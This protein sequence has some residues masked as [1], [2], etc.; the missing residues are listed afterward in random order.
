[1]GP[2]PQ[3]PVLASSGNMVSTDMSCH[4]TDDTL[5]AVRVAASPNTKIV[6]SFLA[7]AKS[8]AVS[9]AQLLQREVLEPLQGTLAAAAKGQLPPQKWRN[10]VA[11]ILEGV[12]AD[13][14]GAFWTVS[15]LIDSL[16][17][18]LSAEAH[19]HRVR[20]ALVRVQSSNTA[21]QAPSLV[22]LLRGATMAGDVELQHRI[23]AAL[24]TLAPPPLGVSGLVQSSFLSAHGL[25]ANS[26]SSSLAATDRLLVG[27]EVSESTESVLFSEAARLARQGDQRGSKHGCLLVNYSGGI[28]GQDGLKAARVDGGTA[29][30]VEP[31][32]EP[33]V[34]GEGWNHEVFEQRSRSSRK[35]VLHAEAHA[36]AD[37]IRRFGEAA[38]FEAFAT[39]EAWIVELPDDAAFDDAP[40][41]RK[42][43][44]LL[45]AVGVPRA[46]HST[47]YG[48]LKRLTLPPHKPH[49]LSLPMACRPLAFACDEAGVRC[50]ALER[51]L[52]EAD[53]SERLGTDGRSPEHSSSTATGT[54]ESAHSMP[55][56]ASLMEVPRESARA[57]LV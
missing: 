39:A 14:G 57:Y 51:A 20:A 11:Q 52:I 47:R 40:P 15:E 17:L 24:A 53:H 13:P 33:R 35:R 4:D 21:E 45:Q 27:A 56:G 48:T 28:G 9:E 26:L 3:L 50:E 44:A 7:T 22:Q 41:C 36:I 1:M 49:L 12:S 46:V 37:A 55:H 38:A 16:R 30:A 5:S 6:T 8:V 10:A 19:A 23:I 29:E 32:P 54:A 2:L 43:A 25:S 31:R 18:C 42:C 34:L